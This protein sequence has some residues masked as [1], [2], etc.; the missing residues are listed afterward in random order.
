MKLIGRFL[1]KETQSQQP[2]IYRLIAPLSLIIV[3]LP[4]SLK[5][6]PIAAPDGTGTTITP[7]G[8]QF[9]ISGGKLSS[10]GAN[11]FHS[12]EKFGLNSDQVANFLSSPAIRNILG[13][14]TGGEASYINGLIRVTGGNSNLYL[15]NPAGLIFGPN[16]QLNVPASFFATTATNIGFDNGWFNAFS[17]SDYTALVGTP[18]QFNFGTIN[19]GPLINLGALRVANGETLALMGGAVANR[20]TLSAPNGKLAIAAVTGENLVRI[21]QDGHL[22]NLEITTNAIKEN[23]PTSLSLPQLLTGDSTLSA[24]GLTINSDGTLQLI[25]TDQPVARGDLMIVAGQGFNS[26]ITLLAETAILSATGHLTLQDIQMETGGDLT[27]RAQETLR[28]RDSAMYPLS[29]IVGGNLTLQGDRSLEIQGV[30]HPQSGFSSASTTLVSGGQ[31]S[32]A[33]S[34][35]TDQTFSIL[36]LEGGVGNLISNGGVIVTAGEDITFG[37]YTGPSLL[38]SANRNLTAGNITI[39]GIDP[40][41]SQE[42]VVILRSNPQSLTVPGSISLGNLSINVQGKGGPVIVEATGE[43][44]T[45]GIQSN[46]REIYL[47][48]LQGAINTTGGTLNS[49]AQTGESGAISLQA[50]GNITT[51]GINTGSNRANAGNITLYSQ[52]GTLDT[53]AGPL[54]ASATQGSGGQILLYSTSNAI[55]TGPLNAT[56]LTDGNVTLYATG[57]IRTDS[58]NS[59]EIRIVSTSGEIETT[60]GPLNANNVISL[61]AGGNITTGDLTI[62]NNPIELTSVQGSID[63]SAGRLTASGANLY[64]FGNLTTGTILTN[65][66]SL[67]LISVAGQVDTRNGILDTSSQT[68]VGGKISLQTFSNQPLLTGDLISGGGDIRLTSG[69]EINTGEATLDSSFSTG[70][71]GNISLNSDTELVAGDIFS[72]GGN[73]SLSSTERLSLVGENIDSAGPKTGGNIF[74]NSDADT[75]VRSNVTTDGGS[76][77]ILSNGSINTQTGILD[78]ISDEGGTDGDITLRSNSAISTGFV[79]SPL[80]QIR[81]TGSSIDTSAGRLISVTPPTLEISTSFVP[82]TPPNFGLGPQQPPEPP[83]VSTLTP[84]EILFPELLPPV[85][86]TVN[87]I[88]IPNP[89]SDGEPPRLPPEPLLPISLPPE[90][91]APS[92]PAPSLPP[93][94][95]VVPP[96]NPVTQLP[97][98][99]NNDNFPVIPD[100]VLPPFPDK[101]PTV[102]PIVP[103]ALLP[104]SEATPAPQTAPSPAV[105]SPK[106]QV[107]I[108]SSSSRV[109][110]EDPPN[111]TA[112]AAGSDTQT[113]A[114]PEPPQNALNQDILPNTRINLQQL[115][116]LA[117]R[118]SRCLAEEQLL[119]RQAGESLRS[120]PKDYAKAIDCYQQNLQF[121]RSV[122]DQTREGYA[123][124]NL[125][126]TYYALGEYAKAITYHEQRLTHAQ[127]TQ[128]ALGQGQALAGLGAAYAAVGDYSKAKNYYQQSLQRA[129]SVKSLELESM[130]LRNLGLI[131][132]AQKNYAESIQYQEQSLAIARQQQDRRSEALALSNLGLAHY[133]LTDYHPAVAVLK[134][135]LT[136]ASELGERLVEGRAR[137][138]LGLAYY[139]L[140]DFPQ[141]VEYQRQSLAIARQLG[142]RHAE[143]RALSNL[144]DALFQVGRPE[145]AVKSLLAAVEIWESVRSNLGNHDLNQISIFE[146][147]ETTYSTLQEVLVREGQ[148]DRALE[149]TER[150]RAQAFLRLLSRRLAST[151]DRESP[152]VPPPNLEEI[153]HIAKVQNSTLVSYSLLKEVVEKAGKRQLQESELLIWVIRPTGEV[154]FR[155]VDLKPLR[156]AQRSLASL[157]SGSRCFTRSCLREKR[158]TVSEIQ[159]DLTSLE[160]PEVDPVTKRFVDPALRQLHRL[161]IEPIA[162][163][164]PENPEDRVTFIPQESLFLV[165]FAALQATGGQYLIEKHTILTAP[166]IQVLAFTQKQRQRVSGKEV[167]VVGNPIMPTV[168][169]NPDQPPQMLPSLPYSE[170]EAMTIARLFNVAA[171]TGEKATK[172]AVLGQIEQARIVHLATHGLLD[173]VE[174]MGMPGVIALAPAAEDNG[175]L[176]AGEIFNLNLGAELVVLSAC[177]T[178]RGRISGDGVIG[179]SRSFISAGVP[180]V[181]VSLWAVPDDSTSEL[182]TEFYRQVQQ[183]P[184]YAKALRKAMLTM[185]SKYP[186]PLDWAA[187]TLIG[188]AAGNPVFS[189]LSMGGR[190]N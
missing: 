172:K 131:E 122:G 72:G 32:V 6:Q 160:R 104:T 2:I 161:L 21:S 87:E 183:G 88:P 148:F 175:L 62:Q 116:L 95:P 24:T 159:P 29:A 94:G 126:V 103:N 15:M 102:N 14:I 82:I 30:N 57:D 178:G 19:P 70:R 149:V 138:N 78:S 99:P 115:N 151:G 164:L 158:R 170:V 134:E 168:I 59:G 166:S 108:K 91:P 156:E 89:A 61:Y 69:G 137:E 39:N 186:N 111:Q 132:Y 93:S 58:I 167:L 18:N 113:V 13:R 1:N 25:N 56:G 107:T 174:G 169:L 34:F 28:T 4:T 33:G 11:L 189:P 53:S 27:L 8:N 124:N 47:N 106:S 45:G 117:Q 188:E 176:S 173:D 114:K 128:D 135:S 38:L 144:G 43:I 73:I 80:G 63:T 121:A 77:Q 26:R 42:P 145:E 55:I 182:M 190:R 20:G 76:I 139:A 120:L 48:S 98:L 136:L 85:P 64:S 185:I 40:R 101:A 10:D 7:Q 97:Q 83:A 123:L 177:N 112:V 118:A 12:F 37:D 41:I 23:S 165:P 154:T 180:S 105:A 67:A 181:V 163:L 100:V 35:R 152:A 50:Q 146:T 187:F 150:G 162:D 142:D 68:S 147:Q 44:R 49:T 157:V 109:T 141:A 75:I 179:L 74:L 133:S 125:G 155:T 46:G 84:P 153:R 81:I 171:L 22:L 3:G 5:A 110:I 65:G 96:N 129:Q 184:D 52:T 66:G 79:L 36:N 143:G 54:E 9:D 130:A 16:A 140:K 51:A 31:I 71:G 127:S 60:T 90:P 86:G 92:P 17:N 119:G